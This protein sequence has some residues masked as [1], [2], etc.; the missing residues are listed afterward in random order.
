MTVTDTDG[1]GFDPGALKEK[2]RSERDKRLRADGTAQFVDVTE[3]FAGFA[4]DPYAAEITPREPLTDDVDVV[5]IGGGLTEAMGAARLR[6]ART[7]TA[8]AIAPE[9]QAEMAP[10]CATIVALDTDHSPFLSRIAETAE[11]IERAT[12]A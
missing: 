4:T 3:D 1:P 12:R 8:Y 7:C 5:V 10:R 11:I 2:Y 9:Y 6:Q